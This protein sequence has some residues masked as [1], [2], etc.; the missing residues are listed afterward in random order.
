MRL[1]SAPP[2]CKAFAPNF[3]GHRERGS[4]LFCSFHSSS[5]RALFLRCLFLLFS[6]LPFP[7]PSTPHAFSHHLLLLLWFLRAGSVAQS[8]VRSASV[9]LTGGSIPGTGFSLFLFRDRLAV[10]HR[11]TRRFRA[12]GA[13]GVGWPHEASTLKA[14]SP[15]VISLAGDGK[16]TKMTSAVTTYFGHR[17]IVFVGS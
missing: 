14:H 6:I 12:Y 8:A 7:P 13:P 10:T 9:P 3:L 11:P 16:T 5:F 1:P 2:G 4:A 17:S 15:F